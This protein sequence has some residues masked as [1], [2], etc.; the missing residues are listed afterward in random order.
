MHNVVFVAPYFIETT[1]R[2]VA[3]VARLPGIRFGLITHEPEEKLPPELRGTVEGYLRV[4]DSLDVRQLYGAVEVMSQRMGRLGRLVGTLEEL[5]VPLADVRA[6]FGIEGLSLEAAHSFRD[7]SRMKD[8]LRAAGVPCAQ[9][10]LCADPAAC[11]AFAAETGFPLVVKPP[12]GAGAR[13]TFRVEGA[14]ELEEWL[15]VAPPA[16]GREALLEEFITG[17][18]H[19]FDTMSI[20]GRALWS[21]ISRYDPTPL[22]VLRNPWIQWC[23]M[24]PREIDAPQW[25]DV[26]RAGFRALE[27]LGQA[28]GVSHME[29]FRRKDGSLAISEIA[30]RP[31]GAQFCTLIGHAHDIDFYAAWARL[32]VFEEFDVPQRKYAA[33]A[34]YLRGQGTG[35]VTAIRGLDELQKE[36]GHLVVEA[37]LPQS[38]QGPSGSYEGE[39]YVIVRHPE[40]AVVEKALARIVSVARVEMA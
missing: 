32:V 7:K 37:K 26:R 20:G 28:T 38:G 23:V 22:E 34:A 33:G 25:D 13:N 36:L 29:W 39:G 10:R 15:A 3:A 8:V 40:T 11:R 24:V 6:H 9:H 5:Q 1:M 19:S 16:P 18:E 12:A 4:A 21:S 14:R 27:V 17:Q 31:P 2:F 30:A 35:R